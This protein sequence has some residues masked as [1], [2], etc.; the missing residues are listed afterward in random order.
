MNANSRPG[1]AATTSER[2]SQVRPASSLRPVNH[3]PTWAV[4]PSS[5]QHAVQT[6]LHSPIRVTSETNSYRVSGERAITIDSE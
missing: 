4:A 1:C 2:V 5:H 3:A 6:G